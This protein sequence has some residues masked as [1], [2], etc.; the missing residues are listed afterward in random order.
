LAT[1]WAL[2]AAL[3]TGCFELS[4]PPS[5][6]SA[7]SALQLPWPSVVEQDVLRDSTGAPVPLRVDAYDGEGNIV[8]DATVVFIPLDPGLRIDADGTVHGES[9]GPPVRVVAQVARGG[10]VL[11]T[12]EVSI[13]VVPRPDTV[14]PAGFD[15]LAVKV[16]TLTG[17]ADTSW[18]TS[19][20][21]NV[22]VSNRARLISDP[23]TAAV[24]SWIVRYE[25]TARPAGVNDEVTAFF[26][27][28]ARPQ[29][30]VDTTDPSGIAARQVILRTIVLPAASKVGRHDVKV[31]ATVRERGQ[32]VPGSPIE[33]VIP[34][35]IRPAP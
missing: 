5:G 26:P 34:F 28:T 33:L 9:V 3:Q 21:I 23:S 1:G 13:A 29:V 27:G 2:A 16:Y 7:I 10:D 20:P 31:T 14:K 15:T 35:D 4:G 18:V 30:A 32:N 12:P 25:I 8:S 11:Q 6:L 22:T 24:R 19:D 17:I